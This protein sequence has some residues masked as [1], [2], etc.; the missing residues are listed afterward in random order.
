MTE[1]GVTS[2]QIVIDCADPARLG[3][4]WAAAL[5]YV[6]EP[7]PSGYASWEDFAVEHEIPR[8]QWNDMYALVPPG[9]DPAVG[10]AGDGRP[11][12]LLM[13]VPE[14]KVVKNR[15]H[16]DLKASRE[17]GLPAEER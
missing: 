5:G 9:L 13:K 4:F 12:I 15:L 3:A 14:G 17:R 1:P 2:F 8:E 16:L 10:H 6:E 7:P 11:R